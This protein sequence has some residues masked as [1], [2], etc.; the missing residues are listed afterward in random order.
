MGFSPNL[1]P[2]NRRVLIIFV[3][4]F[5]AVI[6]E[7][8]FLIN[9]ADGAQEYVVSIYVLSSCCFILLSFT[10][11]ILNTKQL[12]SFINIVSEFLNGSK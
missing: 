7:L 1:E 11:T 10:N 4:S 2:L 9:E 6:F 5:L 8:I 3:R 12:F